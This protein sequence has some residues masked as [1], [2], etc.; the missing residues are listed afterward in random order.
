MLTSTHWGVYDVTVKDGVITGVTPFDRD[1]DPSPIGNSLPGAVTGPL[2][3]RHPAVRKSYL[4]GGAGAAREKRGAE[5]FVNVSW[6]EA[7]DLV[8]AELKRVTTQFGNSAIF[9]GSYGWSSAGRFHHA[10]S[11][12]HRFMNLSLIHI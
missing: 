8:A 5:A 6:N 12:M 7:F 11:Q 2:R 10:Q 3:V 9:A 1:P 4:E